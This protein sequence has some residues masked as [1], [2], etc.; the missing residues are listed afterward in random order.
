M[1][2]D[3]F[4]IEELEIDVLD[5]DELDVR[6]LSCWDDLMNGLRFGSVIPLTIFAIALAG[7]GSIKVH[8]KRSMHVHETSNLRPE[9]A[10]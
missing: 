1:D 2:I 6:E 5:I 9:I 4:D 7:S 10:N 8:V 3:A